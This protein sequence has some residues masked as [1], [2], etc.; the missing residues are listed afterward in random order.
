MW[1]GC[2]P[3]PEENAD[4]LDFTPEHTHLLL[5]GV[6]GDFPHHNDGSHLNRGVTDNASVVGA[7]SLHIQQAGMPQSLAQ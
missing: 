4:L 2:A 1:G 6:Y 5:Q 3:P 7:I